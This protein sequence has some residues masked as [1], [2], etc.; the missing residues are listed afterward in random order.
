M[1]GDENTAERL[2][3][4][5]Y[6]Q[7]WNEMEGEISDLLHSMLI[8]APNLLSPILR[9]RGG[10]GSRSQSVKKSYSHSRMRTGFKLI[11]F[12]LH[13]L[14]WIKPLILLLRIYLIHLRVLFDILSFLNS[15]MSVKTSRK[16][17]LPRPSLF[18]LLKIRFLP[19]V[20]LLSH[21]QFRSQTRGTF[22]C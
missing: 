4:L 8:C 2:G 3:A 22:K 6:D 20:C 17:T 13:F 1:P 7:E 21:N 5:C 15:R 14:K 18:R 19:P 16:Y 10:C 12:T 11:E 9:N